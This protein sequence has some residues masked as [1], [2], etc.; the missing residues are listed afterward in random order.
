[1]LPSPQAGRLSARLGY[2]PP[3]S[4]TSGA[5]LW[6]WHLA[7]SGSAGTAAVG[8]QKRSSWARQQRELAALQQATW[9]AQGTLLPL[10]CSC[11]SWQPHTVCWQPWSPTA[12]GAGSGDGCPARPL[13]G[14][15]SLGPSG[16][17]VLGGF[18]PRRAPQPPAQTEG[19]KNLDTTLARRFLAL[20]SR[21]A[22]GCCGGG[23]PKGESSGWEG[24]ASLGA[25]RK[26][27]P[28]QGARVS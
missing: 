11:T 20:P 18:G 1:M 24:C 21:M 10:S 26:A 8:L 5:A 19:G 6:C 2:W 22:S 25:P 4:G 23:W 15:G 3:S 28:S 13:A 16:A 12:D 9:V 14:L 27:R 17:S 7:V